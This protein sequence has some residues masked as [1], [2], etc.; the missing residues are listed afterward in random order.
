MG[1]PRLMEEQAR[2]QSHE[3][4]CERLMNLVEDGDHDLDL[5]T[6]MAVITSAVLGT[7]HETI[8]R[9]ITE[10]GHILEADSNQTM[11]RFIRREI[12]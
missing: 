7:L 1:D 5:S 9:R 6:D 11:N 2:L 8:S 12:R 10:V 4:A 3:M